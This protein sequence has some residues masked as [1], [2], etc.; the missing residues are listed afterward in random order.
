MVKNVQLFSICAI[1][2]ESVVTH[3]LEN[4]ILDVKLVQIVCVLMCD[5]LLAVTSQYTNCSAENCSRFSS[6]EE[7]HNS[8]SV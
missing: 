2:H 8:I 1:I 6:P 3:R 4:L 7:V 5:H